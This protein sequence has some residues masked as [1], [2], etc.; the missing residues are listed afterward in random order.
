MSIE[1]IKNEIVFICDDCD[2]HLES[3]SGDFETANA[4]RREE[5]WATRQIGGV[6]Q[7]FCPGCRGGSRQ[8][9]FRSQKRRP[10]TR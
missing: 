10:E 5:G 6:W 8:P 4:T 3:G 7:N 9:D 1:R 2:D